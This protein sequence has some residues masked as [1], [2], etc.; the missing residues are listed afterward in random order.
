[1]GSMRGSLVVA[2]LLST[3][4]VTAAEQPRPVVPP[5]TASVSGRVVEASTRRPLANAIITLADLS[6]AG[7]LTTITNAEGQYVIEGVAAGFYR[8]SASLDGYARFEAPRKSFIPLPGSVM[9]GVAGGDV[10]RGV[11]L[12][13]APGGTIT[14]RVTDAEQ[15]PV[16]E[17]IMLAMLIDDSGGISFNGSSNVRTNERGE[18]TIRNLPAGRYRLSVRWIDPEM[19]RAKAG[20]DVE[21][22][23]FPGT[24]QAHEAMSLTLAPGGALRGID[25]R[26]A[27][28]ELVRFSGYVLRGASEGPIEAHVAL[29]SFTIRTATIAADDGAFEVTHLKPGPLTF[30]ARAAT[31]DGFEAAWTELDLGADMT[32]L[33]L[34]MMPTAEIRGR[35]VMNDGAPLP[36]GLQVAAHLVDPDGAR[37]D[38]L[39]R[40]KAD[41]AGDGTFHLHGVFGHRT[42]TVIGLTHEHMLD[43]V[44]HGKSVIKMLSLSSGQSVDDVTLVVRKR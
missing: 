44:E 24:R 26:L 14:G 11:D 22:T 12:A 18:Y 3:L 37:L 23:Y 30:W 39:S 43:R 32:G 35:V 15:K 9:V 27:P 33:I 20:F 31:A 2:S 6:G 13:L 34:P 36:E 4:T 17:G 10:R 7:E 16:K 25:I 28:S 41:I 42:L 5:G 21:P 8:V 19:V 1:M 29:P 38:I 40:D